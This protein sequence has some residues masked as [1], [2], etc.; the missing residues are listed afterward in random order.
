MNARSESKCRASAGQEMLDPNYGK[1]D[2]K[3]LS[4]HLGRKPF[5]ALEAHMRDVVAVSSRY[6][7]GLI[8]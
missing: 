1:K 2:P 6:W 7:F 5:Y 8:M 4:C 3:S